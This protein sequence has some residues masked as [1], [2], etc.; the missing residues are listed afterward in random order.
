VAGT[1]RIDVRPVV[2]GLGW[3]EDEGIHLLIVVP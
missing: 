1:Y 3:L 2:E